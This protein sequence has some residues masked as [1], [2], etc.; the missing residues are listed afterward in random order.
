M[1]TA[2]LL[3]FVAA[4]VLVGALLAF[5]LTLTYRQA[6][7]AAVT[8]SRNEATILVTRIEATLRRV[9]AASDQIADQ[10]ADGPWPHA[11]RPPMRP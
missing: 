9:K 5:F 3:V 7:H 4:A 8:A 6:E 2:P 1:L 11:R 10:L